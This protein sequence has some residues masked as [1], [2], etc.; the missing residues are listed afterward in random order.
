MACHTSHGRLGIIEKRGETYFLV[1]AIE[2]RFPPPSIC[3]PAGSS[4]P[5]FAGD[6]SQVQ[7]A[8]RF[9]SLLISKFRFFLST[10]M[11]FSKQFASTTN[12]ESQLYNIV[13]VCAICEK[14]HKI[15]CNLF[16]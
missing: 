15:S 2:T 12:D 5:H 1:G 8:F 9:A 10:N 13:R 4:F 6:F 14:V 16:E 11:H 7:S 3:S